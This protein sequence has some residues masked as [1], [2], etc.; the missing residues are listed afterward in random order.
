MKD[1]LIHIEG[2]RSDCCDEKSMTF[3]KK[4]K[5]EPIIYIKVTRKSRKYFYKE[6]YPYL[7]NY[8]PDEIIMYITF[9]LI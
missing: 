5:L 9:Y 4:Q 6:I 8:L 7:K 1:K 3:G 2:S